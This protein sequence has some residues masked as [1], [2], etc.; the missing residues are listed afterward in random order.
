MRWN[1]D[2]FVSLALAIT[3]TVIFMGQT[4]AGAPRHFQRYHVEH[5]KLLWPLHGRGA[6]LV[7][8]ANN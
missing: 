4:F 8:T 7:A 3:V 5:V 6:R 2:D 1:L